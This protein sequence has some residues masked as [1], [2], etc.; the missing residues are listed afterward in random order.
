[1]IK[2]HKK[3]LI[4]NK[5]VNFLF[6][7]SIFIIFFIFIFLIYKLI[8][9][10][11]FTD[12]YQIFIDLR[13][14]FTISLD[15]YYISD[16]YYLEKMYKNV[17]LDR[18]FIDRSINPLYYHILKF[19]LRK[20]ERIISFLLN[21]KS[22]NIMQQL[23]DYLK[24]KPYYYF[25]QHKHKNQ[26]IFLYDCVVKLR[27]KKVHKYFFKNYNYTSKESTALEVVYFIIDAFI[28]KNQGKKK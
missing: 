6:I 28:V 2:K 21:F 19:V 7:I 12:E 26:I 4:I 25:N 13:C 20:D 15:S 3:E 5:I 24:N 14:V 10:T 9:Y 18:W 1:M 11:F 16:Y 22:F 8:L 23:I 27:G 17:I